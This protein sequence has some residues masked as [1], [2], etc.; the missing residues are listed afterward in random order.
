M[1]RA[2]G[3]RLKTFF[4]E[5]DFVCRLGGDEFVAV[6]P[7]FPDGR[8]TDIFVDRIRANISRDICVNGLTF[9]LGVSVGVATYP[10]DGASLDELLVRADKL[11]YR[12]KM[13]NRA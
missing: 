9:S 11:M 3:Q 8:K 1:I 2:M 13:K 6:V 12:D 5:S 7:G 4:R 10:Q